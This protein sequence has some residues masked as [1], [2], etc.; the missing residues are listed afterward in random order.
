MLSGDGGQVSHGHGT[1]VLSHLGQQGVV[2]AQGD[3]GHKSPGTRWTPSLHLLTRSSRAL[4]SPGVLCPDG[5]GQAVTD[6]GD[7]SEHSGGLAEDCETRALGNNGGLGP[8]RMS[9]FQARAHLDSSPHGQSQPLLVRQDG[10][11]QGRGPPVHLL[12]VKGGDDEGGPA[13]GRDPW[14]LGDGTDQGDRPPGGECNGQ[15]VSFACPQVCGADDKDCCCAQ[16]AHE[17]AGTECADSTGVLLGSPGTWVGPVAR[18][19]ESQH[20]EYQCRGQGRAPC[21]EHD[22]RHP[23]TRSVTPDSPPGTA[24][25]GERWGEQTQVE[26]LGSLGGG[27]VCATPSVPVLILTHSL[28]ER[29]VVTRCPKVVHATPFEGPH[30]VT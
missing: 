25:A 13:G 15:G 12:D 9:G 19:P 5:L 27:G 6:A 20:G 24:P 17:Q 7:G 16:G 26:G 28:V 30:T 2:I 23:S 10:G 3:A 18:R 1:H 8:P 29:G 11:D 21:G 4:L 14:L 22:D